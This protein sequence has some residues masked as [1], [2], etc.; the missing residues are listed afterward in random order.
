MRLR[1][2]QMG[3][4][5]QFFHGA[6]VR[7]PAIVEDIGRVGACAPDRRRCAWKRARC[8]G[9]A[10]RDR[11]SVAETAGGARGS[12]LAAGSSRISRS[13]SWATA[14]IASFW[15]VPTERRGNAIGGGELPFEHEPAGKLVVPILVERSGVL[16]VFAHLHPRIEIDH[17][18]DVA[19]AF[20]RGG[21]QVPGILTQQSALAGIELEQ[22]KGDLSSVLFPYPLLT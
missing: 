4:G 15:S 6:K 8:G 19:D 17:L 1:Q 7:D 2:I 5:F 21:G 20:L 22:S 13:G 11:R 3:L 9:R 16:D 10:R 18:R 12:R 14:R